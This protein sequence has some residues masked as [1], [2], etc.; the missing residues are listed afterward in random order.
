MNE[1][2][3]DRKALRVFIVDDDKDTL[4]VVSHI[5]KTL[6][7]DVTGVNDSSSALKEFIHHTMR[8]GGFDLIVLDIRMPKLNGYALAKQIR[9]TGYAGLIVALTASTTGEGRRE[10]KESGIDYYFNKTSI[11]KELISALL[12][13][14]KETAAEIENRNPELED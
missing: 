8:V 7:V 4:E 6:K 3:E 12:L 14:N 9:D 11:N 13:Q 2:K 5:F 10:S 1:E